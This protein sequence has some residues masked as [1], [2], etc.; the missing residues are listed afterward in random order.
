M[1]VNV[2]GVWR[3]LRLLPMLMMAS[4][5]ELWAQGAGV[6]TG[7]SVNPDQFYV[8]AH[9][10]LGPVVDRLWLRPNLEAGFG[11]NRTLVALNVEFVYWFKPPGW[12]WD[13][14]LG[15]GPTVNITSFDTSFPGRDTAV[16]PGFNFLVGLGRGRGFFGEIKVGA[17]D[18]PE[19]KLAVG[20]TFP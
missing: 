7:L 8:G 16:E 19:F 17:I 13:V 9:L 15:G 11:D 5:G 3:M 1:F 20:Y 10:G 6:R 18:S 2:G 12:N 4:Q 14:Y